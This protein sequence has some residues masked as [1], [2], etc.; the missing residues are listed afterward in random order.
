MTTRQSAEPELDLIAFSRGPG[1]TLGAL[2]LSLPLA[3]A[4]GGLHRWV[5]VDASVGMMSALVLTWSAWT[6][7]T[8]AVAVVVCAWLSVDGFVVNQFGVLTWDR[9]DPWRLGLLVGAALLGL[10]LRRRPGSK[11]GRA[12]RAV[13]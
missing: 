4:L 5:T 2:M 11:V 9:A 10:A 3:V 13:G 12:G 6:G 7:M 8:G 1:A